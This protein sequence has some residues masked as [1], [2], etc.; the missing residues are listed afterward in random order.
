MFCNHMCQCPPTE[1]TG[2]LVHQPL[3]TRSSANHIRLS[4]RDPAVL[5]LVGSS[6]SCP[7]LSNKID[8]FIH[9]FP[10]DIL[11]PLWRIWTYKRSQR[12]AAKATISLTILT[13]LVSFAIAAT[14]LHCHHHCWGHYDNYIAI[15]HRYPPFLFSS[16]PKLASHWS[17]LSRVWRVV[18]ALLH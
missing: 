16:S 6:A 4:P 1:S 17:Q 2:S 12:P 14:T 13:S 10:W 9:S 5:G 8:A 3:H 18:V 11:E 7:T 15:T